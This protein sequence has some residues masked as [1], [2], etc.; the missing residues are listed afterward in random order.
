VVPKLYE[1]TEEGQKVTRNIGTGTN[2]GDGAK[3]C[4]VYERV[5]D[6]GQEAS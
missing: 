1:S 3:W 5:E 6:P 4:A 2:H